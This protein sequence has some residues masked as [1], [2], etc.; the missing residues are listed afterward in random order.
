MEIVAPIVEHDVIDYDFSFTNGVRS[1]T[2]LIPAL[3]DST[4]ELQDRYTVVLTSKPNPI[5]PEEMMPKEE[6]S[7]F[8]SNITVVIK[9]ERKQRSPSVDE[10]ID[11]KAAYGQMA[12]EPKGL[13]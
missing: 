5:N 13:M 3:G 6:V 9:R 1:T 2:T 7:V 10:L 12:R 4:N 11:I 8:K